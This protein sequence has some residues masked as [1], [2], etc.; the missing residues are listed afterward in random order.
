M[1]PVSKKRI[2]K[3]VPATTNTHTTIELLLETVLSTWSVQNDYKEDNG[4]TQLVVSCQF[5]GSSGRK[6]VK[7]RVC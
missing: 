7:K 2:G 6:A 3:H 1:Q 4:A 5:R